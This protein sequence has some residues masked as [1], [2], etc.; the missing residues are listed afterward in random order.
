MMSDLSFMYLDLNRRTVAPRLPFVDEDLWF[1]A[2]EIFDCATLTFSGLY[3]LSA[4]YGAWD[5][6]KRLPWFN[7]RLEDLSRAKPWPHAQEVVHI[8]RRLMNTRRKLSRHNWPYE[9]GELTYNSI[10]EGNFKLTTRALSVE[11]M[12]CLDVFLCTLVTFRTMTAMKVLSV[13]YENLLETAAHIESDRAD[14]P[15]GPAGAET[16]TRAR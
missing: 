8:G 6:F 9:A 10:P 13:V 11:T 5:T 14:K 12:L 2:S 1:K 4:P 16:G 7:E 3:P 15:E